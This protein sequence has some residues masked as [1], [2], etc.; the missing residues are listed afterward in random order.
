MLAAHAL[1]LGATMLG[2]VGPVINR[3][4]VYQGVLGRDKVMAGR[5]ELI[6]QVAD[7]NELATTRAALGD[8]FWMAVGALFAGK[9][10]GTGRNTEGD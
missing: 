2:I 9:A 10:D 7:E 6:E 3:N 5:E 1:G 8:I 4:N